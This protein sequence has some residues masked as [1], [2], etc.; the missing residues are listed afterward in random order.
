MT[1]SS[2]KLP[3][4]ASV[5]ATGSGWAFDTRDFHSLLMTLVGGVVVFVITHA[6][7]W[8]GTKIWKKFP[9]TV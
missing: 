2:V 6:M 7:Q 5:S 1:L 8:V 3:L 4:I 9:P